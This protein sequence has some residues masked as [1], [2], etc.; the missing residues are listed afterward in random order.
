MRQSRS[1]I[2]R[3]DRECLADGVESVVWRRQSEQ[4][5]KSLP[6]GQAECS[7]TT[8]EGDFSL[9]TFFSRSFFFRGFQRIQK[10]F[11]VRNH[12]PV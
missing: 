1:G 2:G 8:S 3:V 12:L 11:E 9:G 6:P 10:F 4:Y 7:V 5:R